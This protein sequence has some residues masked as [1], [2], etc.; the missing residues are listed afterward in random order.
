M[1]LVPNSTKSLL[2]LM[3]SNNESFAKDLVSDI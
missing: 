2:I 3:E 1:I